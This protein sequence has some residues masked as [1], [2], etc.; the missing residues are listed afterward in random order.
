MSFSD[1]TRKN[2]ENEGAYIPHLCDESYYRRNFDL[3]KKNE[4][5]QYS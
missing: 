3:G 4:T 5:H 2:T 1:N